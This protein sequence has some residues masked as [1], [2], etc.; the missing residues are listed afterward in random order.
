MS[1]NTKHLNSYGVDVLDLKIGLWVEIEGDETKV[2]LI[3]KIENLNEGKIRIEYITSTAILS[4][5]LRMENRWTVP[6][7]ISNIIGKLNL[8]PV[9]C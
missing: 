7:S 6:A 2:G 5:V 9:Y 4:G 1:E 8:N 3:T